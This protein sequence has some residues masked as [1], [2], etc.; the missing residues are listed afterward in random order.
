[1]ESE[2]SRISGLKNQ[3]KLKGLLKL[4]YEKEEV[5]NGEWEICNWKRWKGWST[6]NERV[7]TVRRHCENVKIKIVLR[8]K[9]KKLRVLDIKCFT[10]MDLEINLKKD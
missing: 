4:R 3:V 10:Y 6:D 7:V 8:E 1:M 2:N 9:L 5:V